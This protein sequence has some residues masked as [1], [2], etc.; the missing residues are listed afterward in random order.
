MM[1]QRVA[2]ESIGCSLPPEIFSSADIEEQLQP[3]YERLRLPAGRLELMSGIRERRLWPARTPI[4]RPSIQSAQRAIDAAEIDPGRIGCLIHASV[5]RDYLEPATACGVHAALGLP[6]DC[7]V[8]DLS[9]A[10]L[11][12]LN[13]MVQIAGLIERGIIQA[14]IVVG[15]ES[16]R[17]LLESTI[18][19]LNSDHSLTRQTIKPSFASL[20]IGSGSCAILLVDRDISRTDNQLQHCAARAETTHHGLCQS[21]TD[22]AGTGMQPLMQTD[23]EQLLQAGV[24]VGERTFEQLLAQGVSRDQ[25]TQTV[26]HQ[27]GSTH[28]RSMLERLQL[29]EARDYSTF[30]WLGNT[31]SVAL[32][33]ALAMAIKSEFIKA[34]SRVALLGI[35]SGI[36]SVMLTTSWNRPLVNVELDAAAQAWLSP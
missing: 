10:C 3:V 30:Q 21:D 25:I 16:A 35:G 19:A 20:T 15:T 23:S 4:S 12:L 27:V 24:A 29:P 7:W 31:G 34:G 6:S 1:F 8:Y 13:G 9:N 33:T 32:P 28:R 22:Q 26:C 17:N 11:G 14:G 2:I 36:N 18:A 5:C